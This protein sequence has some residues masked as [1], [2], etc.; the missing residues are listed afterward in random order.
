MKRTAFLIATALA[1]SAR[2]CASVTSSRTA[3]LRFVFFV[4]DRTTLRDALH[5]DAPAI[6]SLLS[7]SGVA[8]LNTASAS[9]RTPEG[10]FVTSSAG[11]HAAATS[12]AGEFACSWEP[13][14]RSCAREVFMRRT[15]RRVG[16]RTLVAL[17]LPGLLAENAERNTGACIGALGEMLS[18]IGPTACVGCPDTGAPYAEPERLAPLLVMRPSG[19]VDGGDISQSLLFRHPDAPFGVATDPA[20]LEAAFRQASSWASTV[21]VDLGETAR[22]E[23]YRPWLAPD[24]V[25]LHRRAAV[26]RADR[27]VSQIMSQIDLRRTTVVLASLFPPLS[28]EGRVEAPGFFAVTGASPGLLVSATTRSA[29]LIANVDILPTIAETL[30][31]SLPRD[32]LITGSPAR[33]LPVPNHLEA[34]VSLQERIELERRMAGGPLLA[35]VAGLA[36]LLV[37]SGSAGA[38]YALGRSAAWGPAARAR[39][40]ALARTAAG[41]AALLPTALLAVPSLQFRGVDTPAKYV[42]ATFGVWA[43]LCVPAVVRPAWA[44]RYALWVTAGHI[45]LQHLVGAALFAK[46]GVVGGAPMALSI[47]ND[48]P[49]IGARFHGLSNE[50]MGVLIGAVLA[51]VCLTVKPG[52]GRRSA[53]WG[54]ALA[55]AVFV[56]AA[57][58]G[59]N[60]GGAA[61]AVF[62]LASAGELFSGRR[63]RLRVL[64]SMGL[65]SAVLVGLLMMLDARSDG[66]THLGRT[67]LMVRSGGVGYLLDVAGRKL[68]LN[69][70]LAV[71][72]RALWFYA[73]VAGLAA[74][75]TSVIPGAARGILDSRPDLRCLVTASAV[76]A[77]AA[78]LFNDTGVIPAGFI[79]A[80]AVLAFTDALGESA[81]A[82]GQDHDSASS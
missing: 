56:G 2:P 24:A 36:G 49:L 54:L 82:R 50:V 30:R 72:P 28:A 63:I 73:G 74:L 7:R 64:A 46:T 66:A 41:C 12:L 59:D 38:L 77:A 16:P 33:S 68:M 32:A 80:G 29:G 14:E 81:F 48:F 62:A 34:A 47:L 70:R 51:L 78:F 13:A 61:A 76:G 44:L 18:Q 19:V 11:A 8:L 6:R 20:K 42:L 1:L 71:D 37:V 58:L 5:A 27:L 57:S 79:L 31:L 67:A 4:L 35:V 39:A 17:G 9:G 69:L 60:G 55:L 45:C 25:P 75:W 10:S 52:R 65:T 22:A 3:H 40:G 26:E 53:L 15:G 21:V 23:A 43:L